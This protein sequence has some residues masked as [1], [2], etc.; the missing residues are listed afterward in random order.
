MSVIANILVHEDLGA[1]NVECLLISSVDNSSSVIR[2]F[3]L[4]A[5]VCRLINRSR[6]LCF[7]PPSDAHIN[8]ETCIYLVLTILDAL[9]LAR[10]FGCKVVRVDA[11]KVTSA[12]EELW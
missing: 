1:C 9:D 8:V 3:D 7:L 12:E 6:S 4:H 5:N 2:V 11:V 10:R